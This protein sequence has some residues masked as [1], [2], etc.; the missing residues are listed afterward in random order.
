MK[1]YFKKGNPAN[2]EWHLCVNKIIKEIEQHNKWN[3]QK[4]R[5][6]QEIIKRNL[7]TKYG[8]IIEETLNIK[9]IV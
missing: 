3:I 1:K 8:N 5:R 2:S 7:K 6:N 9:E 4:H